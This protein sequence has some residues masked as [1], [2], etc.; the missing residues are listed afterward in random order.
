ML[1]EGGGNVPCAKL[2]WWGVIQS[3]EL[4]LTQTMVSLLCQ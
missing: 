2:V 3:L 4:H 1:C